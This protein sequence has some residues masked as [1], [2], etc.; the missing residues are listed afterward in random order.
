MP[1]VTGAA[2]RKSDKQFRDQLILATSVRTKK[3]TRK[4]RLVAD[5]MVRD[6]IKGNTQ[7]QTAIRDTIDG[8]PAQS[9]SVEGYIDH[10]HTLTLD[11]SE[12]ARQLTLYLTREQERLQATAY[13]LID[14]TPGPVTESDT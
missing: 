9:L 3:G 7:A 14:V 8:K 4:L 1:S 10:R 5:R 12:I 13:P 2:H 11:D 6:A